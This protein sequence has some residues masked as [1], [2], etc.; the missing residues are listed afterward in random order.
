MDLSILLSLSNSYKRYLISIVLGLIYMLRLWYSPLLQHRPRTFVSKN[1]RMHVGGRPGGPLS[2]CDEALGNVDTARGDD[3][4]KSRPSNP[5]RWGARSH[6]TTVRLRR[7]KAG[8]LSGHLFRP[9]L[10][11]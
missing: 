1:T 3:P 10:R 6:T 9:E 11:V 2:P 7:S 5:R 8:Q 4:G